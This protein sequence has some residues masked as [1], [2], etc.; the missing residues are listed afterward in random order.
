MCGMEKRD[1]AGRLHC[2]DGPAVVDGPCQQWWRHGKLHRTDGP[3]EVF[4]DLSTG[5]WVD[6]LEVRNA[7]HSLLAPLAA[8]GEFDVLEAVLR[9]LVEE[10]GIYYHRVGEN[11][12]VEGVISAVRAALR[13]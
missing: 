8:A 6:G 7:D 10:K 11:P 5:Y 1:E 9:V 3:A 4:S 12:Y 2:D 13:G